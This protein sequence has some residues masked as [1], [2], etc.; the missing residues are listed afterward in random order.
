MC[1]DRTQVE[2][3]K[4]FAIILILC[5]LCVCIKGE[6]KYIITG[7]VATLVHSLL[8]YGAFCRNSRGGY[9]NKLHSFFFLAAGRRPR[10]L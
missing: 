4:M 9:L 3:A 5:S 6:D 10:Q 1:F 2:S 8:A 7:L